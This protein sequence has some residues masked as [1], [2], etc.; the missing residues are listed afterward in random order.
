M[1][2]RRPP[3]QPLPQAPLRRAMEAFVAEALP[4][5]RAQ[6]VPPERYPEVTLLI[7]AFPQ[8]AEAADWAPFEFAIR[9][10]WAVLGAMQ[11]VVVV[12][13]QAAVPEC[14]AGLAGVELQREATLLP[15]QLETMNRDCLQRLHRRFTTRHV[16]IVQADGW[17]MRD[18]LGRF[19]RYDYV[20]APNVTPG[21]RAMV[22][23]ALALTVLNGGFSL[24]SRR[25]CRA[26]SL[27]APLA[28][29]FPEDHLLSR[30]RPLFRFP[31]AAE[32][33][34][35][36]ED[37][38]DGLLPPALTANPMGFHRAS[39]FA[40]LYAPPAPL[41]VVGAVRDWPCYRRCIERNP[42]LRAARR[43]AFDNTR[44]NRSLPERYNVFL[45]AMPPDTGWILFA[46]ED[47]ELRE[48]PLPLLAR[49]N[50]LF[51]CGLIGSRIVGGLLVL[52]FGTLT[53]SERDGS[54][55]HVNTPPLPYGTLLGNHAEN[56]DCCAL[57][58]HAEAIRA[59]G[60]RFD[61]KCPWDLYVED[62]CFQFL[63]RSGH[64]ISIL[65]LRAHH[66]SRGNPGSERL[67]AVE[68]YLNQKYQAY[69]F[70]GG[71]CALT[72]GRRPSLRLR[73][74]HTALFTLWRAWRK[75]R[76]GSEA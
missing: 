59:W 17:P 21:W 75:L 9:Q 5:L 39:T 45:D 29:R 42:F 18:E 49:R 38:L 28:G 11:T 3:P 10:S 12:P 16:L 56:T 72:I 66:F 37:C 4:R 23:D 19:L 24:R 63:C 58:V 36:S 13:A 76:Y 35:F 67:K 55:F 7:Y 65:P 48:D 22:A 64:T 33:R 74:C 57:F 40:A 61:P 52:P 43:V 71:T 69:C 34:G 2:P 32:A 14:L 26:A 51:P 62:L 1:R 47:F 15:G 20:G 44:E 50:P 53:D 25:L 46:H 27:L 60:L 73:L 6:A 41:T 8:G 68:R 54:R 31:S 70:A 30:L